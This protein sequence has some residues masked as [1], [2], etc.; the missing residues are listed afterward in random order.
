MKGSLCNTVSASKTRGV[1]FCA[2][3]R[4]CKNVIVPHGKQGPLVF[5][6]PSLAPSLPP[7]L[8]LSRFLCHSFF[9]CLFFPTGTSANVVR[10][11]NT[12]TQRHRHTDTHTQTHTSF[13]RI[14]ELLQRFILFAVL[15][16]LNG[17]ILC[18][19]GGVQSESHGR[20]QTSSGAMV[21][22][23]GRV[24]HQWHLQIKVLRT[25]MWIFQI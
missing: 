7:S 10:L 18:A 20:V 9:A 21:G 5:F 23:W 14:E 25:K 17:S 4:L 16:S 12:H 1:F 3:G 8:F 6:V 2:I 13:T 15:L 19:S 11:V 24:G 22:P